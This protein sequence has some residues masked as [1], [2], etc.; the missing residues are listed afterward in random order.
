MLLFA[1]KQKS[2]Y[3]CSVI[4]QPTYLFHLFTLTI[5]TTYTLKINA[6][7]LGEEIVEFD[8]KNAR[9]A[10][11]AARKYVTDKYTDDNGSFLYEGV[12]TL[13]TPWCKLCDCAF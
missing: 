2:Y 1:H 13:S 7:R 8:A 4:N 9:E 12:F 6:F 3:L 5:M 10:R 11:S